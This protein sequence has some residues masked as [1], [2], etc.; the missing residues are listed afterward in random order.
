L[1]NHHYAPLRFTS[2]QGGKSNI[3][4]FHEAQIL[5]EDEKAKTRIKDSAISISHRELTRWLPRITGAK[6]DYIV[7]QRGTNE[8]RQDRRDAG[9]LS[10]NIEMKD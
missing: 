9:F 3:R 2:P 6:I 4:G 7:Y 1:R 8:S 10:V 5:D